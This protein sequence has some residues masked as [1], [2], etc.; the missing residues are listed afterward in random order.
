VAVIERTPGASAA[1]TDAEAFRRMSKAARATIKKHGFVRCL[2]HKNAWHAEVPR[3]PPD[4]GNDVKPHRAPC[5]C[6]VR[7]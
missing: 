3:T 6:R 4:F 5:D 2:D 1:Y 7:K